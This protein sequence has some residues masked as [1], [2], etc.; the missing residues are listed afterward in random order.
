MNRKEAEKLYS[1]LHNIFYKSKIS[2]DYA[3]AAKA[4]VEMLNIAKILKDKGK[5]E[6]VL[7]HWT[8]LQME[9]SPGNVEPFQEQIDKILN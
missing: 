1:K 8:H 6:E 5:K 4:L 9:M 7:K 3:T 2:R